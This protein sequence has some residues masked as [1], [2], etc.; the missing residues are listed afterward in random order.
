MKAFPTNVSVTI[1]H[2]RQYDRQL[3]NEINEVRASPLSIVSSL[4]VSC[5]QAWT[6]AQ[7]Y[8]RRELFHN[9]V[10]HRIID[11]NDRYFIFYRTDLLTVSIKDAVRTW[12]EQKHLA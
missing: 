3:S 7:D 8:L 4:N 11:S 12:R 9:R 2:R 1:V 5:F 6:N 10:Q